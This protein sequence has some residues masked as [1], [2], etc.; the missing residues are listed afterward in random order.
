L[1]LEAGGKDRKFE[2]HA[3]AAYSRLHNS[4]V[5]WAFRTLP[6]A[7]LNNR[8]MQQPRGKVLGGCSSTNCMAYVR[9]N[10]KDYDDWAALGNPGWSYEEVL[11][12]FRKS[13]S[14][15]QFS[16]AFHGQGGPLNVTH[17]KEHVTPLGHAFVKACQEQGIPANPDFNGAHQEGAGLFQFTIK[18][19]RRHS[20]AAAFLKPAMRRPNLKIITH[21]YAEKVLLE[22]GLEGLIA[23]GLVYRKKN[24]S[25]QVFA[26]QE[27]ILSAGAFNSPHLLM[28][29]GIGPADQLSAQGVELRLDLPGVGQNL[30]DHLIVPIC[31]RC[32]QS[33]TYNSAETLGNLTRYLLFKKGPF[34][35]S[36]LEACAFAHTRPGLD[37][38]DIQFHFAPAHGTDMHDLDQIPKGDDGYSILPTL[39]T[40]KSR[41]EVRL[42][43]ADPQ[44]PI[45]IDPRYVSD[46]EDMQTLLKGMR[47]ARD[48]M[49]SQAFDPYRVEICFPQQH[50]SDEALLEHIRQKVETCYHP[51]GT[52]KMGQDEMAV[53]DEEL[54]VRG[55]HGLRV[56]DAS[57][58]PRI[59]AGNTNAPVIMIAE[60][61]A[62]LIKGRQKDSEATRK[63]LDRSNA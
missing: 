16:D 40:P 52:C 36:P 56:A 11:P 54:R 21:A 57:I 20:T 53:V 19:F 41:G 30:Q 37:R 34:T 7:H 12:Y 6:Q 10:K 46:P 15:E 43:S 33:I 62:D 26:E 23:T 17:A 60:K 35:A 39:L 13:E 3:P 31:S 25:F 29:S 61:A 47:M 51:V 55:V 44:V 59:V 49:L 9:G 24:K 58:M 5:D 4:K 38:P 22:E 18:D 2:I 8:V 32:N 42:Q 45:A 63:K 14:N 27:V 50:D 28:L 48:M 1:L